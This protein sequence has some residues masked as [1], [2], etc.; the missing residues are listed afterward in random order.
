MRSCKEKKVLYRENISDLKTGP[1]FNKCLEEPKSLLSVPSRAT[2][3]D[4]SSN[5]STMILSNNC[6]LVYNK[7]F[8]QCQSFLNAFLRSYR[9][10][11]KCVNILTFLQW[12][13]EIS[14]CLC[15]FRYTWSH[16]KRI[17]AKMKFTFIIVTSYKLI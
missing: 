5:K 13:L 15:N 16:S 7:T 8:P 6:S 9:M 14:N 3:S 10:C 17:T 2:Y 4:W 11:T 1:D 12:N